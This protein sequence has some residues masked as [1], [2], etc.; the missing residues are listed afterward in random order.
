MLISKDAAAALEMR[1]SHSLATLVQQEIERLILDGDLKAG[2]RLN[3]NALAARL[4]VSRGPIRE[5]TRG[6]EKA[7]L[8]KLG[9]NRGAFVR[10][11]GLAEASEIYDLRALMFGLACQRVAARRDPGRLKILLHLVKRMDD[12]RR[13]ADA[14]AYYPL[15]LEFHETLIGFADS[16]RLAAIYASLVKEAHLFRRRA[17]SSNV[18]MAQSNAEHRRIVEAIVAGRASQ[19]RKLGEAHVLAG[20][21]RF[22]AAIGGPERPTT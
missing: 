10:E 8:V 16:T 2:E 4:G 9:V 13:D 3:E 18:N 12:V 5:A 15:N 6:L 22:L 17:L 14:S 20:K 7:G 19:A 21:R 1:R 11:I